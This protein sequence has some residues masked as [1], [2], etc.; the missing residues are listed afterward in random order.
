MSLKILTLCYR[1]TFSLYS[2]DANWFYCWIPTF[3]YGRWTSPIACLQRFYVILGH[4]ITKYILAP[5][6]F[7]KL[8]SRLLLAEQIFRTRQNKSR[9]QPRKLVLSSCQLL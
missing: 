7:G 8:P 4:R 5:S 9:R 2:K 1:T 6:A 3:C